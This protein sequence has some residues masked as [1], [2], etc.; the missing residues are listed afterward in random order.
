MSQGKKRAAEDFTCLIK[1]FI[2]K[3]KCYVQ[4]YNKKAQYLCLSVLAVMSASLLPK[5]N[6]M[7]VISNSTRHKRGILGKYSKERGP[8]ILD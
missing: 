6:H 8:Y 1:V 2:D 7:F 5:L 4:L 3:N